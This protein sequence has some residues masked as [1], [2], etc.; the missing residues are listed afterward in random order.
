MYDVIVQTVFGGAYLFQEETA[1]HAT[2]LAKECMTDWLVAK[3]TV[4]HGGNSKIWYLRRKKGWLYI[5][6]RTC[7]N[8][9]VTENP[10]YRVPKP[11]PGSW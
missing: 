2:Q 6:S 1:A 8:G 9:E 4:L 10:E 11:E 5:R 7:I 3:I